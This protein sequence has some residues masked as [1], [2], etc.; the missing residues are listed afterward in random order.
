MS[1]NHQGISHCLESGHLVVFTVVCYMRWAYW[2]CSCINYICLVLLYK[3]HVGS[4][5]CTIGWI[6][7]LIGWRKRQHE[8]GFSFVKGQLLKI[9]W[10]VKLWRDCVYFWALCSMYDSVAGFKKTCEFLSA[11]LYVSKRGAYWDRLCRD[12][13]GWLVGRW[14]SRACT[15]AKRCIMG[16]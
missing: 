6:H 15:V 14:S 7:F 5:S 8:L 3:P 4:R 11:S 9:S 16:L 2:L 13:V 10:P 12:V 1:G